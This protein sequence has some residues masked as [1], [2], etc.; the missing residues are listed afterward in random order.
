MIDW[1]GAN[2][3]VYGPWLVGAM[4]MMETAVLLGLILPAEPTIIVATAFALE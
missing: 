3:A 1:I 4:A 2:L